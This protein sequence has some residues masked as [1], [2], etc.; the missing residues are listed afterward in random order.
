V[1]TGVALGEDWEKLRGR[2]CRKRKQAKTPD[3]KIARML[4]FFMGR[5][6][7]NPYRA[8]EGVPVWG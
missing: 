6:R 5:F 4:S 3:R 7:I 2:A 1:G 8:R